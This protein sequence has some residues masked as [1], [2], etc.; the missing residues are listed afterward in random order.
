MVIATK[1]LS[2]LTSK[3]T[4]TALDTFL[5]SDSEDI[6]TATGTS[7]PKN[8]QVSYETIRDAVISAFS[9]TANAISA[10]IEV[11][12]TVAVG[13]F[14]SLTTG[15][16]IQ[17]GIGAGAN[18]AC[19]IATLAGT[20]DQTVSV[21]IEG[22]CTISSGGYTTGVLYYANETSGA[23]QT[24]VTTLKVGVA[25]SSTIILIDKHANTAFINSRTNKSNPS[26]S[27]EFL[28]AD[29]SD[30][31]K[32]KK[33]T[34]NALRS[35]ITP[36]LNVTHAT[37]MVTLAASNA[38]TYNRIGHASTT[39]N[40]LNSNSDLLV[41]GELEV[42]SDTYLTSVMKFSK[43]S[44]KMTINDTE[45]A[46]YTRIGTSSTAVNSLGKDDLLV[47]GDCEIN[48]ITYFNSTADFSIDAT[49]QGNS[50]VRTISYLNSKTTPSY[51]FSGSG[52]S[53]YL[54][55]TS[56]DTYFD[57]VANHDITFECIFETDS[58]TQT[59]GCLFSK[60][61]DSVGYGV[62]ITS[63]KISL[64]LE[65][66]GGSYDMLLGGDI[67]QANKKAHIFITV[68]DLNVN[69]P[70]TALVTLY[71]NGIT[72]GSTLV[73]ALVGQ[74]FENT[75]RFT[76]GVS[77]TSNYTEQFKGQ[78]YAIRLYNKALT[79]TEVKKKLFQNLEFGEIGARNRNELS[80][81][82]VGITTV[83]ITTGSMTWLMMLYSHINT[84][85]QL[86]SAALSFTGVSGCEFEK[87]PSTATGQVFNFS[88]SFATFGATIGSNGD[89]EFGIKYSRGD[90]MQE[91]KT[92]Y[93]QFTYICSGG[94]T[95][96][97]VGTSSTSTAYITG[98]TS[99]SMTTYAGTI[100]CLPFT[101]NIGFWLNAP[102]APVNVRIY[103]V[104][105]R[106]QGC[107][108]EFVPNSM[109]NQGWVE[110]QQGAVAF[111][112]N[113]RE[114]LVNESSKWKEI[115]N[116]TSITTYG[117]SFVVT[118]PV[119][120]DMEMV[121]QYKVDGNICHLN[122][123]AAY[124]PGG[125]ASFDLNYIELPFE[126]VAGNMGSFPAAVYPLNAMIQYGSALSTYKNPFA[127][128]SSAEPGRIQFL[129][130]ST[131]GAWTLYISGAY[132]IG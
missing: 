105:I 66:A 1:K 15:G 11:G 109:S 83:G 101:E 40:N 115:V 2:E 90:A 30:S 41:T 34:V 119:D 84:A 60:Q 129:D 124:N 68:K 112:A 21:S 117:M 57:F 44:S 79:S 81:T 64:K 59:K 118:D 89:A 93:I 8:K 120:T 47:S 27:D 87:I 65:N 98:L 108:V 51:F 88:S 9:G 20:A 116:I 3:S 85:V 6:S 63:A 14:V 4:I 102:S 58:I 17:P 35:Y 91:N 132:R 10:V 42:T 94:A 29:S 70:G 97:R 82:T 125:P 61:N 123:S 43:D 111:V 12:E 110:T 99:T 114:Q 122:I 62:Y 107:I 53:T 76:I 52:G 77:S 7:I 113:D 128:I 32:E 56:K 33:L 5:I 75:G 131:T 26:A 39:A 48:G 45:S 24:A 67:I 19:G 22:L 25:L 106:Q 95:E 16:K 104:I 31:F 36:G 74:S 73:P 54:Q 13:V 72:S 18:H 69:L 71:Y 28:I 100:T 38:N 103:D 78:I 37:S 86:V 127:Y 23:L 50:L 92:Y 96:L 49:I 46:R 121:M 80:V 55:V 130:I 126:M